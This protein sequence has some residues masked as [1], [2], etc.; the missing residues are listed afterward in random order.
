MTEILPDRF[1]VFAVDPGGTTG[2]AWGF[3]NSTKTNGTLAAVLAR[4][5]ERERL[6]THQVEGSL[7]TQA[8]VIVQGWL[9]F[10]LRWNV[11]L[12]QPITAC[13]FVIERFELRQRSADLAPV[14]LIGALEALCCYYS[15]TERRV[16]RR[17]LPEFQT[18]SDAKSFATN[19]RLRRWGL[20]V[21]G[22]EHARDANRHLALKVSKL[23]G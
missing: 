6:H 19:E 15:T 17:W 5:H 4:A 2:V 10:T 9:E 12:R 3:F 23:L 1:A 13:Y 8:H 21:R 18:A 16:V 11:D 22:R 7:E 14:T 20:W